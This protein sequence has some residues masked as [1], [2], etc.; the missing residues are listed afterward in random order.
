MQAAVKRMLQ[1]SSGLQRVPGLVELCGE[2]ENWPACGF[3]S[4]W[5]S[6]TW[7]IDQENATV[8]S[9]ERRLPDGG[10]WEGQGALLCQSLLDWH[11]VI[12]KLWLLPGGKEMAAVLGNLPVERVA[13]LFQRQ[14]HRPFLSPYSV[15]GL[16]EWAVLRVPSF[17]VFFCVMKPWP[18][19]EYP[20]HALPVGWKKA[21]QMF[22]FKSSGKGTILPHYLL[23]WYVF[24]FLCIC[25]SVAKGAFCCQRL[26]LYSSF[27]TLQSFSILRYNTGFQGNFPAYCAAVWD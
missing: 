12:M 13:F 2:Q 24:I 15:V 8:D 7:F 27:E 22:T 11:N 18:S 6:F 16:W 21:I 17:T 3:R 1:F 23:Q 4:C 26:Y 5:M 9:R 20:S 25:V 19:D 14:Q 10:H